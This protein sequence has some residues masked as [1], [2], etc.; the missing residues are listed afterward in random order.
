V[1]HNKNNMDKRAAIR[2]K[3]KRAVITGLLAAA[4]TW[5]TNGKTDKTAEDYAN[6]A[7][8]IAD[9]LIAEDIT[10]ESK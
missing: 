7:G 4:N 5:A 10:A 9:A 6:T 8:H 2:R 1:K 3:Y